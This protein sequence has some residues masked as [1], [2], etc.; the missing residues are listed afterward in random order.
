MN[1]SEGPKQGG[2]AVPVADRDPAPTFAPGDFMGRTF[3]GGIKLSGRT[4]LFVVIGLVC[5]AIGGAGL[6]RAQQDLAATQRQLAKSYELASKVDT[7]G[8][9][10][11]QIRAEGISLRHRTPGNTTEAA[12]AHITKAIELGHLLDEMYTD[13][14]NAAAD[15]H[16]TTVREAV[17]Q[18]AEA[19]SA[20]AGGAPQ[21]N[22]VNA[23]DMAR[24][25]RNAA[26]NLQNRLV[27]VNI[28]SL[29]K[30]VADMR[31]AEA[32]FIKTGN[33]SHL[34]AI[35]DAQSDF[36]RLLPTVPLTEAE[37]A[38]LETLMQTYQNRLTE[39][40][41][42]KLT[43]P[44][45]TARLDEI[46]AYMT[47]SIDAL[48]AYSGQRLAASLRKET[49][50]RDFYLPLIASIGAALLLIVLLAGTF[51]LGSI[52]GPVAAAAQAG[53][54]IAEGD[55]DVIVWGLGND[56]ETGDIAKA[57]S[58]LKVR[59]GEIAAIRE[60][61]EKAK[62]EA[63]RGRAAT[64]EAAWLR[65]DLESMKAE[66]VKGQAAITEVTLLHKVIEAM[67]SEHRESAA[68]A[69]DAND[70]ALREA[71]ERPTEAAPGQETENPDLNTISQISQQV[72]Q[73]SQSVTAAAE[74]A[75][76][77]GTLIRSLNDAFKRVDDIEPLIKSIGEQADLLWVSPAGDGHGEPPS[78][79]DLVT[80]TPDQRGD[81]EGASGMRMESS[82]SR[83][84]DIIRATASQMTWALRDIN[85]VILEARNLALTI[86]QTTSAEALDVTTDLL[87]QS[88]NLRYML[89]SLV[90]KMRDQLFDEAT[91]S[92]GQTDPDQPTD[93]DG[94]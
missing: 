42:T 12:E 30:I 50:V 11:W 85:G 45:N 10:A 20:L 84:F 14:D 76:R 68:L 6:F 73:S 54:R 4:G 34:I 92:D 24:G 59:L 64:E 93:R 13:A 83:R 25:L 62:S 40:A 56:D 19:Y 88:E 74:E 67:R 66:L 78:G 55:I 89:D 3:M 37:A 46:F 52:T 94:F 77:T 72:A 31:L 80:F 63:E 15:E 28:V 36:V 51:I 16:I 5:L 33:A 44:D 58:I 22:P 17:A 41:K 75:E 71:K 1:D 27:E 61:V 39:Y 60:S 35:N 81:E 69:S 29:T 2:K 87:E 26:D 57:F 65:H 18:Y 86:A 49:R 91:E 70:R 32:A 23:S 21:P 9:T 8:L 79:G 48:K 43:A 47:S 7:V 90:H 82:I 38:D 53:R